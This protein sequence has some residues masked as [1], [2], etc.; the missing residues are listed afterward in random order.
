MVQLMRAGRS[1]SG[2]EAD[3]AFLNLG[4]GRFADVSA[5]LGLDLVRDGRSVVAVDWDADGDLDLLTSGRDRGRFRYLRNDLVQPGVT[6]PSVSVRLVAEGL[7]KSAVGARVEWVPNGDLGTIHHQVRRAGEGFLAQAGAWQVLG[8]GASE[9]AEVRVQWPDGQSESFGRLRAGNRGLLVQG[10]G[11]ARQV[12]A[13]S[14]EL[15][16]PQTPRDPRAQVAQPSADEEGFAQVMMVP[17][18]LPTLGMETSD[19]REAKLFGLGP[20]GSRGTGQPLLLHLWASWCAPCVV[21]LADM[22]REGADLRASGVVSLALSL[23]ADED[24]A[25]ALGVLKSIEWS[26]SR[27]FAGRD[28]A[29]VLDTVIGSL[30]DTTARL[31]LPTSLLISP[32]GRLLVIY[33]G[34]V[35]ASRVLH[36]LDLIRLSPAERRRRARPYDGIEVDPRTTPHLARVEAALRYRGFEQAAAE[37]ALAQVQIRSA[38]EAQIAYQY[39]VARARQGRHEQALELFRKAVD[40]DPSSAASWAAL[41]WAAEVSNLLDE[42]LLAYRKSLALDGNDA[43]AHFNLGRLSLGHGLLDEAKRHRQALVSLGSALAE[44]LGTEIAAHEERAKG[45]DER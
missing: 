32:E 4:G 2:N 5:S 8:L 10:S 35:K 18:P 1:W 42:A 13:P 33:T 20:S 45:S 16:G 40:L 31:S 43:T 28:T 11:R 34:K 6:P 36:D 29:D 19:G 17:M 3:R 27:G 7:N 44:R 26:G 22:Q 30:R 15:A 21:E 39:G 24:R 25:K 38:D 12:S 14:I 9:A 23:D 41:G 37:Y